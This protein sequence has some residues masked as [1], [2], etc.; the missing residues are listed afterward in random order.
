MDKEIKN[1][2]LDE[3]KLFSLGGDGIGGWLTKDTDD[4][5]FKR[6][7]SL[8]KESNTLSYVQF[9]Q[10]LVLSH[11]AP[12]TN[13]FFRYYWLESPPKHPYLVT[14]LLDFDG[15]W[16]NEDPSIKVISPS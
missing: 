10:L 13:D 2:I 15:K 14:E 5:I 4:K 7:A 11:I 8:E 9:K 12:M 1:N 3:F 16:I 6:L